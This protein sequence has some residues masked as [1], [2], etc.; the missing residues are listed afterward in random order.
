MATVTAVRMASPSKSAKHLQKMLQTDR[1][2]TEGDSQGGSIIDDDDK[3]EGTSAAGA[4]LAGLAAKHLDIAALLKDPLVFVPARMQDDA[5][6]KIPYEPLPTGPS[7]PQN[8]V[9]VCCHRVSSPSL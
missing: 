8:A 5:Q 6:F 9:Q 1:L 3:G 2:K 4:A 7:R